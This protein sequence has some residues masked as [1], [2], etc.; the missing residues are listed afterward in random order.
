MPILQEYYAV[1]GVEPGASPDDVKVAFRKAALKYHPDRNQDPGAKAELQKAYNAYEFLRNPELVR[2]LQLQEAAQRQQ[3][4]QLKAAREAA[5]YSFRRGFAELP[6]AGDELELHIVYGKGGE[7]KTTLSAKAILEAK[8]KAKDLHLP[9]DRAVKVL[10]G[11]FD[12]G[13]ENKGMRLFM[14][15]FPQKRQGEDADS[16]RL[17]RKQEIKQQEDEWY[18][19]VAA[20]TSMTDYFMENTRK[21]LLAER[22]PDRAQMARDIAANR[23]HEHIL[24]AD[25]LVSLVDAAGG[26]DSL[27]VERLVS[28]ECVNGKPSYKEHQFIW[29][30]DYAETVDPKSLILQPRF[31]NAPQN[32]GMILGSREKRLI[33]PQVD[34]FLEDILSLNVDIFNVDCGANNME[35]L[36]QVMAMGFGVPA[37]RHRLLPVIGRARREGITDATETTRAIL[38]TILTNMYSARVLEHEDKVARVEEGVA[39]DIDRLECLTTIKQCTTYLY[40]LDAWHY[41]KG[42]DSSGPAQPVSLP[43]FLD[44]IVK[45]ANAP[46]LTAFSDEVRSVVS[47][48][49]VCPI[50]TNMSYQD[51]FELELSV[52]KSWNRMFGLNMQ[53]Q[54]L[55]QNFHEEIQQAHSDGSIYPLRYPDSEPVQQMQRIVRALHCDEPMDFSRYKFTREFVRNQLLTDGFPADD[56]TVNRYTQSLYTPASVAAPVPVACPIP[57]QPKEVPRAVPA[58]ASQPQKGVVKTAFSWLFGRK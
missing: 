40:L 55:Y 31:P 19:F 25:D 53:P 29:G 52:C 38:Y 17:R 51:A 11:N 54:G 50:F 42:S 15:I 33:K 13:Y 47:K 1:L 9:S 16:Y 6:A 8:L 28:R 27:Y 36:L 5:A 56:E 10:Y 12:L 22:T 46:E 49:D 7:G 20:N 32:L 35:P 18:Q 39:C 23:V 2:T 26:L 43:L 14:P 41:S 21:V 4:E 58:A 44:A 37:V 30:I 48:L 24:K 34:R 57:A 45:K 3:V